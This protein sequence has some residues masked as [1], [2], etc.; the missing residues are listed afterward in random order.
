MKYIFYS[1]LFITLAGLAFGFW[2]SNSAERELYSGFGERMAEMQMASSI[3]AIAPK[4][5][6]GAQNITL[7]FVGD[8]MLSRGVGGKMRRHNDYALPFRKTYELLSSAD[9]TIGNLE[10][11]MSD[12]GEDFKNLYSFRADPRAIEGL[13]LAGFDIMDV[14]NNHIM[15]WGVE[16]F[17]D[18]LVRLR[19]NGISYSGAGFN[20]NEANAPIIKDIRGVKIAFLSFRDFPSEYMQASADKPGISTLD[21]DRVEKD[22]GVIKGNKLADVVVVMFHWGEEYQT[23]FN[24]RQ[25][26]LARRLID[27]GVDLII[28]HHPHVIQ[29]VEQYRGGW[30]AYSLGNFTFDQHFSKETMEGLILK[31]TLKDGA[32]SKIET[33]RVEISTD[34]Q[35]FIP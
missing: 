25:Q 16:A 34:F 20:F 21:I 12:R 17:K 10:G 2:Y 8:I 1:V 19:D 35:P 14:N 27:A 11:P 29:D 18:T 24:S 23:M 26:Y 22:I 6:F 33:T 3:Q 7:V 4:L 5:D 31:A 15:D 30:V 13:L 28:G 32:V 9:L